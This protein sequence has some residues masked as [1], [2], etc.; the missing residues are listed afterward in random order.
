MIVIVKRSIRNLIF[1]KNLINIV[2]FVMILLTD[3]HFK[4]FLIDKIEVMF[5][6]KKFVM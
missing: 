6:K 5:F 3:K 2:F 1:S 4:N